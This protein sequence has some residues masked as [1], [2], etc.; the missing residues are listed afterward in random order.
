MAVT[1]NYYRI[2][3]VKTTAGMQEILQ[4]LNLIRQKDTEGKYASTLQKN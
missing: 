2:L 3:N 1:H 4:A